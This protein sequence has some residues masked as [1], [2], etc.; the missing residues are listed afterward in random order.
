MDEEEV[1]DYD[2]E[3]PVVGDQQQPPPVVEDH[4]QQPPVAEDHQQR[5]P[6]VCFEDEVAAQE[7][8]NPYLSAGEMIQEDFDVVEDDIVRSTMPEIDA[9]SGAEAQALQPREDVRQSMF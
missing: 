8:E 9:I 7:G 6:V 2:L 3:D 5:R 4:Q 1:K